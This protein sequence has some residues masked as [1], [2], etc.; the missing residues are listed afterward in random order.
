MADGMYV[1]MCGAQARSD[2]LDAVADNL[3]NAQTPG[4]KAARPAFETFLASGGA[5]DKAYPAAVATGFDLRAGPTA[6]TSNQLDVLPDDG[7][8]LTVQNPDGSIAFTR[9]GRLTLDGAGRLVSGA[10]RVVLDDRGQPIVVPIDLTPIVDPNGIVRATDPRGAGGPGAGEIQLGT[11]GLARLV[12]PVDRVGPSLLAPGEGGAA[13]PAA[14]TVRSGIVELGNAPALEAT[15]AMVTV[16]RS[17][18]SSMQALQTYRQMDQRLAD[19]G[20]V[21]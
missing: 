2:Q 15:L 14:V 3:A 7:A 19:V 17:F 10:G 4:F 13:V 18:D 9:D 1:S 20:R 6:T 21:R 11:L 5:P 12:G 8:F 16:Q